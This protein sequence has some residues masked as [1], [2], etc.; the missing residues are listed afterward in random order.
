M[1]SLLTLFLGILLTAGVLNVQAQNEWDLQTCFDYAIE[2]NIQIKRQEVTTRY[3]ETLVKQAKDDKLP[4]LNGQVS[5]DFSFGRSLTYDNTYDNINSAS[6]AGGLSTS[7]T[8]YNGLTLSNTVKMRELDLQAT[9][10]DLQKTKD[11]IMLSISAEY[12]EILFA[13]ELELV[14]EATIEVTKQQI[15]R[16]KQLVDA[17]SEA[18]GAL[19]EIEAQLAREEL[20]LV[21]AQNRVQLAYLNLY[22]YLELPM[23][24]SFKIEKPVL[25]EIQANLT[26]I[27]AYDVFSTAINVRPEIKAAQLRVESASKQLAIAKGNRYPSLSFGANYYNQYN[28]QYKDIYGDKID[29]GEQLKNN[30]RSSLGLTLSVPIFNRFQAKN[31]ITTSELQIADYEYQ[32]QQSRNVLRRDIEQVYTNALA[33]LNRYLSSEKA[34]ASMKEAFRYTEEKFNVGMINS[35]EYNQSKTNLT[36]AQSDLVQA[37]YEYIFRTKILDF[38][39]GVPITL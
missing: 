36:N 38:Y 16:T 39:N 32:L 4:N 19:L 26:M 7:M 23:A 20:D 34:V 35:V 29:L 33:A 18:R 8:L 22:Q 2:N 30:S 12:L 10:A 17:G 13:E 6:V 27:N 3:N 37:K 25:P 1:K 28:N 31:N 14:A 15:E 24:E 21:N 5:N 9:M 11:D